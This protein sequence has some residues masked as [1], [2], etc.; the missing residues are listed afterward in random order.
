NPRLRRTC[1]LQG[2][3]RDEPNSVRRIVHRSLS[4]LDR[5]GIAGAWRCSV[6]HHAMTVSAITVRS[7]Q[8]PDI[9]DIARLQAETLGE[10]LITQLG[11]R[12]VRRFLSVAISHPL[13]VALIAVTPQRETVGF[14]VATTDVHQ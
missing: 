13:T 9:V 3:E 5:G 6:E 14:C 1:H 4:A 8:E 12:F 11:Q 2:C 10:S 7:I